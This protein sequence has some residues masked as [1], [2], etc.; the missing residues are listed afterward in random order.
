MSYTNDQLNNN[1]RAIA[2]SK[3]SS[4][5][6]QL[7]LEALLLVAQTL[8]VQIV[9]ARSERP[10]D[11]V[12]KLMARTLDMHI[13]RIKKYMIKVERINAAKNFKRRQDK[14][15]LQFYD[16][17]A[18]SGILPEMAQQF[19]AQRVATYTN[20]QAIAAARIAASVPVIRRQIEES[21]LPIHGT[22][23]ERE[24]WAKNRPPIPGVDLQAEHER[25]MREL[26]NIAQGKPEDWIKDL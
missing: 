9:E 19:K 8:A 15:R 10:T 20:N 17:M 18:S 25:V 12:L 24:E 7:D 22:I 21:G 11:R 2:A 3:Y 1:L 4:M 5:R 23:E 13:Q 26:E 14:D 16:A 6:K